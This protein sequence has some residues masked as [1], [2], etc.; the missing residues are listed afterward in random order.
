MNKGEFID[1]LAGNL[2]LSRGEAEKML[3]SFIEVVTSTLKSGG[4]VNITGFGAFTVSHRAARTGVNPQRPGEK[5]QIA[6]TTVPKFKA[7]KAFKDA[8]KG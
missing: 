4:E 1:A 8:I 7:G 6:A 2:T 3:N 5:I